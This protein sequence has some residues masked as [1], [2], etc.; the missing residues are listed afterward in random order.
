M[1]KPRIVARLSAMMQPPESPHDRLNRE[2]ARMQ[3]R[4]VGFWG[5]W[6][7][8]IVTVGAYA[9]LSLNAPKDGTYVTGVAGQTQPLLTES[10]AV[11]VL[12]V[13]VDGAPVDI[14]LRSNLVHPT[15]GETVCLLRTTRALTSGTHYAIAPRD[16]C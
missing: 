16:R 12:R 5:G 6:A 1:D 4:S 15:P 10:S 11:Q 9:F 3:V 7:V 2:L 8:L 14:R 13:T